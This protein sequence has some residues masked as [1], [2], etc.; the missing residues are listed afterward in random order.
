MPGDG[1]WIGGMPGGPCCDSSCGPSCPCGGGCPCDGGP[2]C[3]DCCEPSCGEPC[4][5]A[6]CGPGRVDDLICVG[7]GDDESCHTIRVRVPKFQ[8]VMV[9]AGVHG[10]KGPL[11]L[12]RDHG[13]FGFNEGFN[14]GAKIPFLDWGYQ[15]GYEATQ[16]ELSG[17]SNT[18]DSN[19]FTQSF[20]TAGLFHRTP[21]G[22]QGGVAWDW[23]HDERNQGVDL[24]QF[25][26][27]L[28][29]VTCGC[30]ECG[31][32]TAFHL[33]DRQFQI[34]TTG[35]EAPTPIF[36]TFQATNQYLLF[37][38]LHGCRGGEGRVFGGVT[39]NSDGI[40][41]ADFLLPLVSCWSLQSEFTYLIPDSGGSTS[42]SQQEAWNLGINLVWHW[43]GHARECHSNPYRPLF[44]VADNGSFIVDDR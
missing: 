31:V 22:L 5:G 14:V 38:R 30:H 34:G 39:D 41:G 37:Y 36:T 29:F 19:A 27:E 44:N 32:T 28:S 33:N 26:A 2:G 15:F 4:C 35:G 43:K 42:P 1:Q 7:W 16:S 40:V 25:R 20:V 6:P 21:D 9:D 17:D 24:A 11:D 8:E 23:M 10:F 12:G 13:N 3:G 18:N